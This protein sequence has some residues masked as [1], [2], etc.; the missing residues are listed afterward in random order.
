MPIYLS[1]LVRVDR[2]RFHWCVVNWTLVAKNTDCSVLSEDVYLTEFFK[3][4]V[5]ANGIRSSSRAIAM[6]FL[7]FYVQLVFRLCTLSS[8]S[9]GI[10]EL[11]GC[12]LALSCCTLLGGFLAVSW[13]GH[14]QALLMFSF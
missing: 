5:A 7:A 2:S 13:N 8:V 10:T 4:R 12:S 9:D 11:H 1:G 6:F 14:I 3:V